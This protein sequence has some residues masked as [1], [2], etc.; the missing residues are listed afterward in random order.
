ML[1][2]VLTIIQV[3]SQLPCFRPVKNMGVNLKKTDMW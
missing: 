3:I 1:N 2:D